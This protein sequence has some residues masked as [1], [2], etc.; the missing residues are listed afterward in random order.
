MNRVDIDMFN[1]LWNVKLFA[2]NPSNET[3]EVINCS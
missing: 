2:C 1:K 3:M